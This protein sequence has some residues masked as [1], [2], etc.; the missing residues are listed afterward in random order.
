MA[1]RVRLR[2]TGTVQGVGY[3]PFAYRNATALALG[4]FVLNDSTGVLIQAEGAEE[5]IAELARRPR[6]GVRRVQP[7][8]AAE[9][10]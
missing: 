7:P 9:A 10:T 2:I 5:A 1:A 8:G 6:P 4:G 3:R